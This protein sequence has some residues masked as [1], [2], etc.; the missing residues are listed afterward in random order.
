MEIPYGSRKENRQNNVVIEL[1]KAPPDDGLREAIHLTAE[2]RMD[3][4][5]A[6]RLA[7]TVE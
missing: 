3:C 2:R 7:M 5:V 1:P 6:S 4:F